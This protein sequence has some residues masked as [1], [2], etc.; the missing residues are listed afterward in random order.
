LRAYHGQKSS[1]PGIDLEFNRDDTR[2]IV[3]VKSG[4]NWGNS[5]QYRA[6][7]ESFRT[8]SIVLRQSRQ[9]I[10]VQPV[11]GICYGRSRDVDRGDY[12]KLC[13]QSFWNFIS[14]DPNLYIDIVEPLGYEAQKRNDAFLNQK[15][16]TYNRL[17][18][19]FTNEFCYET[20]EI[21]WTK[22]VKF[23]SGNLT[24]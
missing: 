15:T 13:G 7:R 11:P 6:L 10:H 14:D 5:S 12:I 19:E 21:D 4:P 9:V 23:N 22:L 24:V 18:R 2:F 16:N 17:V 8:A 3:A 20:G 1:S